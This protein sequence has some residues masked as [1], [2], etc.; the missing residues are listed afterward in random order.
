MSR[1]KFILLLIIP[2][3]F[4]GILMAYLD[5][6]F[7]DKYFKLVM[8]LKINNSKLYS[9]TYNSYEEMRVHQE[10]WYPKPIELDKQ[11]N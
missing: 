7:G 6:N 11:E 3:F 10:K 8:V 9:Q 1:L 4:V 5:D 2:S